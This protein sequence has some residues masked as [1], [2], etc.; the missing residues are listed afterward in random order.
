VS[1]TLHCLLTN[2]R[3]RI[4]IPPRIPAQDVE[5]YPGPPNLQME[6]MLLELVA[7]SPI[8]ELAQVRF[9]YRGIRSYPVMVTYQLLQ[10]D[11]AI[12]ALGFCSIRDRLQDGRA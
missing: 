11:H 6:T 4:L 9:T 1:Q 8:T 7:D 2:G 10:R 3:V 12:R 5:A